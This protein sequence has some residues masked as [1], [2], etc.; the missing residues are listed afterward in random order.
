MRRSRVE[1]AR[2]GTMRPEPFRLVLADPP[3][4]LQD[5]LPGKS[6]GAEKNYD[7]L[8]VRELMRYPLPPIADDALL[9]IWKLAS[10][11]EEVLEVVYAWGFYP[12]SEIVWVKEGKGGKMHFGM[13]RYVRNAHETCLI[14]ARGQA[15]QY[16]TDRSIR[17]VF[18][19]P[20]GAHS[21][22]PQEFYELAERLYPGPRVELFSRGAP[23]PGWA[24]YGREAVG[25]PE[26]PAASVG[27]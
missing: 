18:I 4:Q 5:K 13:G 7:V 22:K 27:A 6:R 10:M 25:S 15:R 19:A 24:H 16:I 23:R 14:A 20:V 1:L 17:S 2:V 9:L 11:P 8:S 21:E 3:W 26:A 12:K